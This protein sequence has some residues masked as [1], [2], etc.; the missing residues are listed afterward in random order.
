MTI[1][2]ALPAGPTATVTKEWRRRAPFIYPNLQEQGAPDVFMHCSC[3]WPS[4][5]IRNQEMWMR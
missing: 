1:A 3:G 2:R 4:R 5:P